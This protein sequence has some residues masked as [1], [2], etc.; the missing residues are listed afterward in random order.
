VI[1]LL[2]ENTP[3]PASDKMTY[4]LARLE[5]GSRAWRPRAG[6]QETSLVPSTAARPLMARGQSWALCEA[7][8]RPVP[9]RP[10]VNPSRDMAAALLSVATGES[11]MKEAVGPAVGCLMATFG[12][13]MIA[14][15]IFDFED[16]EDLRCGRTPHA[17]GL[18]AVIAGACARGRAAHPEARPSPHA[19]QLLQRGRAHRAVGPADPAHLRAAGAGGGLDGGAGAGVRGDGCAGGCRGRR[20]ARHALPTP[21]GH[22][23]PQAVRVLPCHEG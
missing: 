3:L 9:A 6:R 11:S 8:R 22:H 7:H 12:T 2:P 10:Q 18:R 5:V 1:G 17:P 21:A 16:P 23:S 15:C 13:N 4:L 20:Q 19:P 14:S